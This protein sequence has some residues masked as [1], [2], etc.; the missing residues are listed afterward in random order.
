MENNSALKDLFEVLLET[1]E[2]FLGDVDTNNETQETKVTKEPE[3]SKKKE[4]PKF[5]RPSTK[6]TT[7]QGLQLHKLVQEYVDTMIKPMSK[8]MVSDEI[9]ND[10]YVG[11]YEFAAW[12]LLK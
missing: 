1:F 6:L 5:V 9:I 4:E 3:K 7:E 11:L 12:L 10:A 2:D 8:G